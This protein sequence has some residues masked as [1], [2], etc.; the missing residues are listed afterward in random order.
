MLAGK[1][2]VKKSVE[3]TTKCNS[4]VLG[5]D[6]L[7]GVLKQCICKSKNVNSAGEET[8]ATEESGPEAAEEEDESTIK[9]SSSTSEE[10]EAAEPEQDI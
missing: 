5:K 6:P 10:A 4:G 7:P 2:L 8:E 9:K 3:G 1:H